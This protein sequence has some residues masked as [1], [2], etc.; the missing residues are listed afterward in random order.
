M[1]D[2]NVRLD[3]KFSV[4]S[5]FWKPNAADV[6]YTGTLKID[7]RFIT[8]TTAPEY[9]RTISAT[10][11]T[12]AMGF[13]Q[14]GQRI[15][16]LHGFTEDGLCTLCQLD[17]IDHPGL[18]HTGL[19]QSIVATTYQASACINGMHLGSLNEKCLNSARYSFEGLSK[20]LPKATSET[21]EKDCIVLKVPFTER[22]VFAIGLLESRI[23]VSLKVF[24]ELTSSKSDVSRQSRSIP[25]IMVESSENESL[26]W[27]H[28]IGNR[29]E[30]FF[31]LL[32]GASLAIE[33]MF[34]NR[35]EEC[36]S[37]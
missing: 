34:V 26:D 12:S 20:W 23:L 31:S 16:V 18:K 17:E 5:A 30:N 28:D 33:T 2:K 35:G 25:Y 15:P 6:V 1:A 7:N 24:P 14:D 19:G 21:W 27:Y 3:S 22:E 9:S 29:L 4:V 11:L 37:R 10:S 13:I 8:F 32:S 36:G